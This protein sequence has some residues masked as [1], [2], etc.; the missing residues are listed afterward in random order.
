V[1]RMGSSSQTLYKNGKKT[2]VAVPQRHTPR[3]L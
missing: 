1:L 2:G 3:M